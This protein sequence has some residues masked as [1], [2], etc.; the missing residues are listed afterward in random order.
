VTGPRRVVD[1]ARARRALAELDRIAREHPELVD[2]TRANAE[3]WEAD[4]PHLLQPEDP[5]TMATNQHQQ[6]FRFPDD[7]IARIDGYGERLAKVTGLQVSRADAIR[8]LVTRALD[9]I[10]A[11]GGNVLANPGAA[12]PSKP[13]T[14]PSTKSRKAGK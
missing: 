13:S 12:A 8:S 1:L 3:A 7:L 2:H 5:E 6:S 9:A 14:K 4:L 10:D 11:E